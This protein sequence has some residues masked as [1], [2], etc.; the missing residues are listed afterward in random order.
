MALSTGATGRG[1]IFKISDGSSPPNLVTIANAT[2]ISPTGRNAEEIDFT[3]LQSTGGFREFRQGFK[4]A[5]TIGIE[6]HFTPTEESHGDLLDLWDSGEVVDWEI[7]FSG[8]G[9]AYKM[10]GQG[11]VQNPGDITINVG[12]PISGSATVRVTGPTSIDAITP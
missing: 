2:S 5:G 6:Y 7:D 10:T 4:D 8:A 1:V 3:H 11:F 9:W 12:D